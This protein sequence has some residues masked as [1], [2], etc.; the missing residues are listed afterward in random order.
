M[1]ARIMRVVSVRLSDDEHESLLRRAGGG[2]GALS[3]YIRQRLAE[4]AIT[5]KLSAPAKTTTTATG[6]FV[7]WMTGHVGPNLTL[8][9]R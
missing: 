8:R 2:R 4:P 5:L 7:E 6:G 1:P 9:S 3:N